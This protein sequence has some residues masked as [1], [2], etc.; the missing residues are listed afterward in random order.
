MKVII[1][2]GVH[3]T[4]LTDRF[5]NSLL[6]IEQEQRRSSIL[7]DWLIFPAEKEPVYSPFHVYNWLKRSQIVRD[8]LF[9][10]AFS[11]GVV[12]AISAAVLMQLKGVKIKGFVAIDGWGVPL[13]VTFPVYRLSHDYFTHWSSAILGTGKSSFYCDPFVEHLTLWSSPNTCQGWVIE[14]DNSSERYLKRSSA[15][16]YLQEILKAELLIVNQKN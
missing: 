6:T 2:P 13:W 3:E 12:G 15:R 7:S 4:Q 10:I 5:L 16:D 11:A 14:G 9:F 1:C 8:E